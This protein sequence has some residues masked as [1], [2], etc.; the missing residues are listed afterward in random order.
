MTAE[1]EILLVEDDQIIALLESKT[2]EKRGYAVRTVAS[3]EKALSLV[4]RRAASGNPPDLVLMDIDLGRGM[5]GTDAAREILKVIEIPI[6]FLTSHSEEEMVAKVRNITRYGYVLK[7]SGDFVLHSSIQMAFDL[8]EANRKEKLNSRELETVY[9]HTP[10][11]MVLLDKD[12]KIRKAN[13]LA[14]S[15][16][17][18]S[19]PE[20]LDTPVGRGFNCVNS[21]NDEGGCGYGEECRGCVL[22]LTVD[23]TFETG[24]SLTGVEV[25]FSS[26]QTLHPPH[27]LRVSTAYV[28]V[29]GAPLVLLNIMDITDQKNLEEGISSCEERYRKLAD[30]A[31]ALIWMSGPDKMCTFFNQPWLDFTGRTF[32]EELG[33]GWTE[34]VHPEDLPGCLEAYSAA[35]DRR[36]WFK[37]TYRLRTKDGE[38]RKIVDIGT[39]R[40]SAAGTFAGYIGHC[41]DITDEL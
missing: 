30:T 24:N 37:I 39:P 20:L 4:R 34:G 38:Y 35:F 19:K 29:N 3:G 25:A 21:L 5:D 10:V 26:G 17:G 6:V 9:H 22:R 32:E 12:R 33:D 16:T 13:S 27:H 11:I 18:L 1:K 2:L 31:G 40:Y 15:Y 23:K 8:F 36:E 28:S 41:I 7:N 14:Q